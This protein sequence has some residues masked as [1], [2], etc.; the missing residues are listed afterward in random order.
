MSSILPKIRTFSKSEFTK[1]PVKRA[2]VIAEGFEERATAWLACLP[3]RECF[4]CAVVL[5]NIPVRKSRLDETLTALNKNRC[6]S[7]RTTDFYRFDP[8]E[9]EAQ[10]LANMSWA[11]AHVQEIVI[12]ISVMSKLMILMILTALRDFE[13]TIR[14]IYT[15]PE[16]YSPSEEEFKDYKKEHPDFASLATFPSLGVHN[17]ERVPLLSSSVMHDYPSVAVAFT[18]FNEN[19]I[20]AF[21]ASITVPNHFFLINGIPPR[22]KWR[23]GATFEVHAKLYEEFSKDNLKGD[24]GLRWQCSTFDYIECFSLLAEFYRCHCYTH[25]VI[26]APTGSKLQAVA[27][28]LLKLCC[29]DVHIEYP[30][31]ES[32]Y[33]EG[34]SKGGNTFHEIVLAGFN[35]FILN[36]GDSSGLNG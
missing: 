30:T 24:G 32:F 11:T 35:S 28:A 10:L 34:L 19:L 14:I 27:C 25:R 29:H 1:N 15:E 33:I 3:P 26:I 5:R 31:P 2:L 6:S 23:A 18:S 16:E 12:D 17:V 22:L 7:I 21:L 9:G 8:S 36:L 13:G 20:R 4:E